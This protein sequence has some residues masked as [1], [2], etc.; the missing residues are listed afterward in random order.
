MTNT[1]KELYDT[2]NSLPD[3]MAI[4]VLNYA[5][6]LATKCFENNLP[7][8][9]VI[10]DINDLKT[11]LQNRASKVAEGETKEYSVDEAFKEIDKI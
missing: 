4:E 1:K 10:K 3:S 11:K 5:D 6:Y 8:R 9:L 2:I 7:D